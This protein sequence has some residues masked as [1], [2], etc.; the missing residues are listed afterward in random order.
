MFQRQNSGFPPLQDLFQ[1]FQSQQHCQLLSHHLNWFQGLH[2]LFQYLFQ[3]FQ[4][5]QKDHQL[6]A[7]TGSF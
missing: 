2:Q 1:M 5:P 3:L 7:D 6:L 4:S